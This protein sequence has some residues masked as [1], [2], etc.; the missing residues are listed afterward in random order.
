MPINMFP[1]LPITTYETPPT[2]FYL[3]YTPVKCPFQ[4]LAQLCCYCGDKICP[5]AA[6]QTDSQGETTP[7]VL[8]WIK[9]IRSSL[10][11]SKKQQQKKENIGEEHKVGDKWSL[12]HLLTTSDASNALLQI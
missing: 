5:Q 12:F 4:D 9:R 10:K 1:Y 11:L 8:E 6:R 7:T 2:H 3:N